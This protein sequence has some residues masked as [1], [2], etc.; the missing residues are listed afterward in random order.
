[1]FLLVETLESWYSGLVT[2]LL[3]KPM[4]RVSPLK[5]GRSS[6][7]KAS[8]SP[9]TFVD[10]TGLEQLP[11][12]LYKDDCARQKQLS[13]KL[14]HVQRAWNRASS[15]FERTQNSSGTYYME[16]LVHAP[17]G[18][19]ASSWGHNATIIGGTAFSMGQKG[20]AIRPKQEYMDSNS[21]R[22]TTGYRV[23]LNEEQYS[24][25][26]FDL[27]LQAEMNPESFK[28]RTYRPWNDCATSACQAQCATGADMKSDW[29]FTPAELEAQLRALPGVEVHHYPKR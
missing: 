8:T 7:I 10:P 21:F 23:R 16:T 22:D 25:A 28:F 29:F 20:M 13:S 6:R 5:A 18:R 27:Y 14:S 11:L 4:K 15:H 26:L 9:V 24:T 19:F 2:A 12:Q 17:V 3:E 1:M